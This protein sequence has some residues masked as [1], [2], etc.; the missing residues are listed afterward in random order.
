MKGLWFISTAF[1]MALHCNL[2]QCFV[3]GDDVLTSVSDTDEPANYTE[4][5]RD[6]EM[7]VDKAEGEV[8]EAHV[9]NLVNAPLGTN[10]TKHQ[11]SS[12]ASEQKIGHTREVL[13]EEKPQKKA[14][15]TVATD[16]EKPE[17]GKVFR[18]KKTVELVID[19][20]TLIT[21]ST[22]DS[23]ET[24]DDGES[25]LQGYGDL[26]ETVN[27]ED[28]G[29]ATR[30][31]NAEPAEASEQIFEKRSPGVSV[32]D[33]GDSSS[34]IA[35][36]EE[37]PNTYDETP[38]E[39]QAKV[40]DVEGNGVRAQAPLYGRE[41][42]IEGNDSSMDRSTVTNG[43]EM[44]T[45][46]EG[47]TSDELLTRDLFN[48]LPESEGFT[49]Y[50]GDGVYEPKFYK[51]DSKKGKDMNISYGKLQK[52]ESDGKIP[53]IQEREWGHD[54]EYH[55]QERHAATT[56]HSQGK[57]GHKEGFPKSQHYHSHGN[58]T[59]RNHT[60]DGDRN[61][62]NSEARH[63]ES[64]YEHEE[65][66]YTDNKVR[67]SYHESPIKPITSSEENWRSKDGYGQDESPPTN[68]FGSTITG[69]D[70]S[71]S[72][73]IITGKEE[74]KYYENT[75]I[76]VS[77]KDSYVPAYPQFLEAE[78]AIDDEIPEL[79]EGEDSVD[80]ESPVTDDADTEDDSITTLA[81][82]TDDEEGSDALSEGA[83]LR[84]LRSKGKKR[85]NKKSQAR[86]YKASKRAKKN[87]KKSKK[88]AKKS[89]KLSKRQA[90]KKSRKAAKQWQ[91]ESKKSKKEAKKMKK[92]AK[93]AKKDANKAKYEAKK[94][95]K[96]EDKTNKAVNDNYIITPQ[97]HANGAKNLRTPGDQQ[98]IEDASSSS[99]GV[100]SADSASANST[101][102]SGLDSSSESENA[103]STSDTKDADALLM[104]DN[105]STKDIDTASAAAEELEAAEAAADDIITAED[106]SPESEEIADDENDDL[107]PEDDNKDGDSYNE[108]DGEEMTRL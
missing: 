94:N 78:A 38:G 91:I 13:Y 68:R 2:W 11:A 104:T 19:A 106:T 5:I 96:D 88:S 35:Q 58:N 8:P 71:E 93:K 66:A 20:P 14:K 107:Y 79:L 23:K 33:I 1:V 60:N 87:N 26:K 18:V 69:E 105:A 40:S 46:S 28:V 10:G 52:D 57:H 67:R 99:A 92:E 83:S 45:D 34:E 108:E 85:S 70:T 24:G 36:D 75:T 55:K 30:S 21:A 41:I 49:A 77:K 6:A 44:T 86:K 25:K 65:N 84:G 59:K 101:E 29:T 74:R 17:E 50:D 4:D 37:T 12:D 103:I 56:T 31:T 42:S 102:T 61:K 3:R 73:E 16:S 39:Y 90:K 54:P 47:I 64:P 98:T 100:A 72:E 80:D 76:E 48:V 27:P 43:K 63:H 9:R 32:D 22:S 7:D 15:S 95:K 97:T 51:S 53:H 62:P 89:K 81:S 82:D